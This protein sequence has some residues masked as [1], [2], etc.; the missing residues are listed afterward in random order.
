M[1]IFFEWDHEKRRTSFKDVSFLANNDDEDECFLL[2]FF[3]A[4]SVYYYV[5]IIRLLIQLF[6]SSL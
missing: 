2:L 6:Y 1:L 5:T 4:L 3:E